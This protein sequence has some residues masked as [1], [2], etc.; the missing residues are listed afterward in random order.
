MNALIINCSPV[1]TGATAE[2]VRV[3]SEQ[4]SDGYSVRCICIDDYSFGFCSGYYR[5]GISVL[6]GGHPRPV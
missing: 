6:L 1:R 5:I 3:V 4:L 2:I